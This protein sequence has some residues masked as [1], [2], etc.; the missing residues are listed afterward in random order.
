[1]FAFTVSAAGR[2]S[3]KMSPAQLKN[4]GI[5]ALL[6][7]VRLSTIE[8][9]FAVPV[10]W[11]TIPVA[12]LMDV[13]VRCSPDCCTRNVTHLPLEPAESR[14]GRKVPRARKS[15]ARRLRDAPPCRNQEHNPVL[16]RF[17]FA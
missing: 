11:Q 3:L 17:L 14:T 16:V 4:R 13:A 12:G 9:I 6:Q 2:A 15:Q 8:E 1:M 7:V 10:S 5:D